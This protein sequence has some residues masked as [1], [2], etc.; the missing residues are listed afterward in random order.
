MVVFGQ[1]GCIQ[2]KVVL[3]GQSI[4]IRSK[5]VVFW[6]EW[7]YSCIV[8]VFGQSDCIRAKWLYSVKVVIILQCCCK[9]AKGLYWGKSGYIRAKWL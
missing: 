8:N 4:G 9:R 6:P 7:F 5:V 2:A 3:L 1:S